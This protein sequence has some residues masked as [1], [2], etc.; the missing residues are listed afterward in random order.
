[1]TN[2][3]A[4]TDIAPRTSITARRQ[5]AQTAGGAGLGAL[6]AYLAG[7][8]PELTALFVPFVTAF[9]AILGNVSRDR[10]HRAELRKSDPFFVWDIGSYL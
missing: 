10:V 4:P 1:M 8:P 7:F 5:G 9:L 6:I 3:Q 2:P